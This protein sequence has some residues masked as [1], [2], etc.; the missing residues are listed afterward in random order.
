MYYELNNQFTTTQENFEKAKTLDLLPV[1]CCVCNEMYILTKHQCRTVY[2]RS[3]TKKFYCSKTCFGQQK[4]TSIQT[5]CTNCN[6]SF[7]KNLFE[8]NK[9]SNHFCSRSCSVTYNNKNKTHGTRRSKLEKYLEEQLTILY[10]NL[11][12]L[13]SNKTI[14]NSE[15]DIY[16]PSLKLA[17]EIQGIFHYEPIYGQEKL[18]QIQKNDLEKV[19]ICEELNI[20][21]K[22]IDISKQIKF[23]PKT[24]D[25][26]LEEICNEIN[27]MESGRRE[28]NSLSILRS[29]LGRPMDNQCPTPAWRK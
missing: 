22:C 17:F 7:S 5:N 8:Y 13:Y 16:I 12:I 28:S 19:K 1:I 6:I 24:S 3:K 14:I 10:P 23:N 11:E 27:E 21:L 9:S 29:R 2:N 25:K 15:L 18:E 20:T 26:Y 4:I